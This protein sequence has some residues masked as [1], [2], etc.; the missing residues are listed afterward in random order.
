MVL[1]IGINVRDYEDALALCSRT[2]A[3]GSP[4]PWLSNASS[5]TL[6]AEPH[7]KQ[8]R[9]AKRAFVRYSGKAHAKA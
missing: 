4:F 1:I 6:P 5:P 3:V 7:A 8:S 2:L 9:C